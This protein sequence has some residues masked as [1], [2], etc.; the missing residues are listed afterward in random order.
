MLQL[1]DFISVINQKPRK[2]KR[3]NFF[4]FFEILGTKQKAQ[5]EEEEEE[6]EE[7]ISY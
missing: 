3:C 6:E 1:L 5:E 4:F 7:K 2:N